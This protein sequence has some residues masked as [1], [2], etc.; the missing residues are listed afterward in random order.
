M[1][2]TWRQGQARMDS[3]RR[4]AQTPAQIA[5]QAEIDRRGGLAMPPGF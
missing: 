1:T 5:G 4:T 2:D 3:L